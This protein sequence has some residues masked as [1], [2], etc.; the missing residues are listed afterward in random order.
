MIWEINILCTI[1]TIT[2]HIVPIE[3]KKE[4]ENNVEDNT[5][6]KNESNT[7]NNIK[8]HAH[9]DASVQQ[10]PVLTREAANENRENNFKS[11]M[12]H[13]RHAPQNQSMPKFLS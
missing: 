4:E 11:P 7:E 13:V 8:F 2:Q 6:E 12:P 3:E 9:N 5:Q 10:D 1:N